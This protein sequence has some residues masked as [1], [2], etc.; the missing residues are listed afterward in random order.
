MK[1]A[2]VAGFIL[3]LAGFALVVAGMSGQGNVSTGGFVFIGPF[4]IVFGSDP[5][6]WQLALVSVVIGGIMLVAFLLWGRRRTEMG[7]E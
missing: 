6:G 5:A 2:L 1:K 7:G 4:P 3:L